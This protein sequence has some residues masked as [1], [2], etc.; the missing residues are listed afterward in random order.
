FRILM[1]DDVADAAYVAAV[2]ERTVR[3]FAGV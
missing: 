3:A 1:T 2:A